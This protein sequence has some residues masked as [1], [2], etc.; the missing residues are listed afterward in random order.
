MQKLHL[1]HLLHPITLFR[2]E[3]SGLDS[4]QFGSRL[5]SRSARIFWT[6]FCEH[7]VQCCEHCVKCCELCVKCRRTSVSIHWT[8][9]L[10]FDFELS[11][12]ILCCRLCFVI[13]MT[14]RIRKENTTKEEVAMEIGTNHTLS[15]GVEMQDN[16]KYIPFDSV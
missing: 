15:S 1:F 8:S 6:R 5:S 9:F 4:Y 16:Q 12:I 7:C 3:N 10:C 2:D 11:L 14:V 13:Y